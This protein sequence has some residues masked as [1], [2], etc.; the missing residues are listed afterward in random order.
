ML[1]CFNGSTA[2]HSSTEEDI[3]AASAVGFDGLELKSWKMDDFLP[4][5]EVA[6]LKRQLE[7]GDLSPV[8]L[9]PYDLIAFGPDVQRHASLDK[10]K[11]HAEAAARLGVPG[12]VML[13]DEPE[14]PMDR[15]H[16][17]TVISE[18]AAEYAET[19]SPFGTQLGIEPFGGHS[20][21]RGPAEAA[22]IMTR[23]L[24][25]N[26]KVVMDT[27]HYYKN[28]IPVEEVSCLS[29]DQLL[30]LHVNDCE[31]LPPAEL[32]DRHRLYPGLGVIPILDIV[33]PMIEAG[34]DGYL[35]VEAH[36]PEY[37]AAPVEVVC[38]EAMR[39]LRILIHRIA[40]SDYSNRRSSMP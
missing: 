15:D 35:S 39:H 1:T 26:I 12:F 10:L 14:E 23:C 33:G 18:A 7:D 32:E 25:D 29:P 19:L 21:F 31:D 37:W 5:G 13:C 4:R 30:V 27:F 3:A 11:E 38:R 2:R 20:V 24:A 34:Y 16:A 8:S 28:R 40:D 17:L 6:D 22:D 9:G 36:R